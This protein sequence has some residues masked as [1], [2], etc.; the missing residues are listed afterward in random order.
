MLVRVPKSRRMLHSSD[1]WKGMNAEQ[2]IRFRE[3]VMSAARLRVVA[4]LIYTAIA[5]MSPLAAEPIG[6]RSYN[7]PFGESSISGVSSDQRRLAQKLM[8]H[9]RAPSFLLRAPP[10]SDESSARF[11]S[12][13]AT[14]PPLTPALGLSVSTGRYSATKS[15]SA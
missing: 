2:R 1:S 14:A 7:A 11:V 5:A 8:S 4:S 9:H 15:E 13:C 3:V 6:L 12:R 10:I